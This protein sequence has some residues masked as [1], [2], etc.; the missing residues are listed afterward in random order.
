MLMNY[1]FRSGGY[2]SRSSHFNCGGLLHTRPQVHSGHCRAFCWEGGYMLT[3]GGE[4]H[5]WHVYKGLPT[6]VVKIP[7]VNVGHVC[8]LTVALA[9]LKIFLYV[10][11]HNGL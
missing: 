1:L 7:H 5:P 3:I 10:R 6:A 9:V 2:G 4:C 8:K 11:L